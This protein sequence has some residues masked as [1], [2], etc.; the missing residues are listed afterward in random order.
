MDTLEDIVRR[1]AP[2]GKPGLIIGDDLVGDF[3]DWR[4]SG[5]IL[6][7]ADVIVARRVGAGE[8][9]APFPCAVLDN[10]AMEIS[11]G[12]VRDRISRGGAWRYLV[13]DGARAIIEAQG[14]YGLSSRPQWI[15]GFAGEWP[16]GMASK[17]VLARVEEAAR[18][19][20]GFERFLHSRNTALL[21]WDLC[22]RFSLDPA[23]GYLAGVAHDLAKPLNDRAQ[24]RL[25]KSYGKE[26]SPIER[27]KPSLLH[28]RAAAVLLKERFGIYND[29]ILEAVAAHTLG[30]RRMGPLAKVVYI[31]D[32]MEVTRE[33]IDPALRRLVFYGD[34]LDEI[35]A[36]TLERAVSSAR[37][38]KLKLSEETLGLL[39]KVRSRERRQ[40]GKE[41]SP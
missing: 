32:K 28:G 35:F 7:M 4:R 30:D 18:E 13:P 22:R 6:G 23:H 19:S 15:G 16:G 25:A 14:L 29:A 20:M 2:E 38:R 36:A 34:D 10:E 26:I 17:N 31:A 3:P 33:K 24:L 9:D 1:Y 39:D 12:M 27:E 40:K 37:S 21:A 5:E 8:V 41:V 11:S